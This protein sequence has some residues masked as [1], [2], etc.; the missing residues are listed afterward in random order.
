MVCVLNNGKYTNSQNYILFLVPLC[1]IGLFV[2]FIT[3]QYSGLSE[4]IFSM[5]K[6]SF[7]KDLLF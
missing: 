3:T 1:T 4:K 2:D 5:Q 7:G 6:R